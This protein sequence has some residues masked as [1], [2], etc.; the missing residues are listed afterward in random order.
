MKI[1]E[2][3]T[4][5]TSIPAKMGA[6]TEIVVEELTHSL[7]KLGQDV[8]I[9]DV[10]D[11]NRQQTDL[12]IIE[13]YLPSFFSSDSVVKLG[14]FHK[15]KRVLYSISLTRK[16][17]Q[18]IKSIPKEEPI[19]LHFHNQYN[20]F[21]F[22]K[23]TSKKMRAR[24]KIGYTIHSYIWFGAWEAIK[25]TVQKRY[26]QEI[27][28]C[29]HADKVFVLNSIVSDML[30]QHIN[31]P[32]EKI[33]PIINGVNTE[34]YNE[35]AIVQEEINAIR[36]K[37]NLENKDVVFQVGSVCDRKNQLSTLK[38]LIPLMKKNKNLVFCYAGGIIDA[39]YQEEIINL[40]QKENVSSQVV[41]YG[42]I[43]PGQTLNHLYAISKVCVINSKSEAFPLV[44]AEALSIPRPIFINSTLLDSLTLWKKHE[45]NGIIRITDNFANDLSKLLNDAAF[46][47]EMQEKGR[48]T[49]VNN[50]SWD[51]AAK[52]YLD[53]FN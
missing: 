1:F 34:K 14:V 53:N 33:T 29:K 50:Y 28:C 49:I 13:A 7:K 43:A 52:L 22:E 15:I 8:T 2:I 9:I 16:L 31:I 5:Y 10:A 11:K 17:H 25:N 19:F 26:F 47:K 18:V 23:L 27:F 32:Q 24:V 20:M 42:E 45:G 38:L 6:A 48:S 46:Y 21:F 41:Y 37:Y 44:I 35:N 40:A 4:G 3:G 12:P 51:I 30:T 36:E 39:A